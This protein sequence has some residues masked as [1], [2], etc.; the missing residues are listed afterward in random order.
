[1]SPKQID[2]L[3]ERAAHKIGA[4]L[5]KLEAQLPAEVT[6]QSVMEVLSQQGWSSASPR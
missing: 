1:M 6:A 3:I 4:E 5:A 2:R